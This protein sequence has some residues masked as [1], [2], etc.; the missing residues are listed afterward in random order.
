MIRYK[1]NGLQLMEDRLCNRL[2]VSEGSDLS[3]S[4]KPDFQKES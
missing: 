1:P 4:L 2:S 3:S